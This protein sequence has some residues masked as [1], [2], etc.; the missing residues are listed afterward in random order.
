MYECQG[1]LTLTMEL[2]I[3]VSTF[4]SLFLHHT[5]C[6]SKLVA[7]HMQLLFVFLAHIFALVHVH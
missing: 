4:Q 3:T 2:S 6:I 7:H 5:S 1:V